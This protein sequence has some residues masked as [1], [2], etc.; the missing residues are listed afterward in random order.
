M[1]KFPQV[2]FLSERA[3]SISGTFSHKLIFDYRDRE[4]FRVKNIQD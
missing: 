3:I 2:E 4:R 1:K